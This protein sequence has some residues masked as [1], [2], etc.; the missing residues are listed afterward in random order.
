MLNQEMQNAVNATMN[1]E[2]APEATQEA[3]SPEATTTETEQVDTTWQDVQQTEENV[4]AAEQQQEVQSF[5]PNW[6]NAPIES[7]EEDIAVASEQ[8]SAT[9]TEHEKTEESTFSRDD[10]LNSLEAM[11]KWETE[12][13]QEVVEDKPENNEI[14]MSDE[15][16]SEEEN[17]NYKVKWKEV[18][19]KNAQLEAENYRLQQQLKFANL[20]LEDITNRYGT[21]KDRQIELNNDIESLT[22]KVTHDD[23]IDVSDKYRVWKNVK[24]DATEVQLVQW[25]CWLLHEITWKDTAWIFED[26]LATRTNKDIPFISSHSDNTSV[27][28]GGNQWASRISL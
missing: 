7:K 2:T 24:N 25:V 5:D 8:E 19:S 9:I 27:T 22:N 13:K 4:V 3:V 18:V 16:E 28:V 20:N 17:L 12:S 1:A 11:L 15:P 14:E 23:L 10:E 21:L 6:W 26:Y